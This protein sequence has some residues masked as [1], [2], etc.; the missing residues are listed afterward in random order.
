MVG[1]CAAPQQSDI[2]FL[3]LLLLLLFLLVVVCCS[4][5]QVLGAR[6]I[7]KNDDFMIKCENKKNKKKTRRL[8]M[9]LHDKTIKAVLSQKL[10]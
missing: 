5:E 8:K 2:L 1:L 10:F 9:R 3:L 4:S 6:E 7:I